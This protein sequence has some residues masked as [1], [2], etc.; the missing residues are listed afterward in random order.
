LKDAHNYI[1]TADTIDG[2]WSDP[3]YVNSSGFDPSLFHNDDGRV[4][5]PALEPCG[6]G[7]G[8][9]PKNDSFDGI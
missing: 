7:T 2:D 6:S 9:S 3:V 1:V 4:R 5:Q 8:G